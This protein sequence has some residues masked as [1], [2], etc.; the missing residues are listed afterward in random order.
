MRGN[1]GTSK[2]G[3]A[4]FRRVLA[5]VTAQCGK[6]KGLHMMREAMKENWLVK[7]M[8]MKVGHSKYKSRDDKSRFDTSSNF[9]T[10]TVIEISIPQDFHHFLTTSPIMCFLLRMLHS[11]YSL[12][13][14]RCTH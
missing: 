7:R 11:P 13:S 1:I 10:P 4:H 14:L 2:K 3:C 8:R 12:Y 9:S 6:C 5:K